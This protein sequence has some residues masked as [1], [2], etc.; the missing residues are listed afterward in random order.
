MY[1][2][3]LTGWFKHWDFALWDLLIL[4]V[5][6]AFAYLLR[7]GFSNPYES[8][9]YR[10][11][12]LIIL[13]IHIII[14]F[15]TEGYSGIVRR[16]F[17]MEA[18]RSLIHS[19]SVFLGVILYEVASKTT[20]YYSRIFVFSYWLISFFGLWIGRTVLKRIV[21]MRMFRA[22]N[23][24]V[25]IIMTLRQYAEEIIRQMRHDRFHEFKV[26][27][28]VL[29]D[30]DLTGEVIEDVPVVSSLSK[31]YEYARLNV[32]D[33]VFISCDNLK[34]EERYA[35][36][37]IEMGITAHLDILG[38][39]G[40]LSDRLVE[41]CG[42]YLVLTSSMNTASPPKLFIKR[43]TD[44]LGALVGL[45]LTGI[46]FVI[47]APII[48]HQSPGPVF[49]KQQRIGQNGRRFTLYKFRSMYPDADARKQQLLK[50]NEMSG[51]MFK[52]KDDPRII[53]IGRFMR[54]FS[55]DE[56][57]QF[58]NVLKGDMSL[59]GTRPPTVEEF[60]HYDMHHKARLGFRPG[61]T[62]L[63]QISGRNE[64]RDFE[65]VVALDTKY[66]T[67]WSLGLDFQI[68]LKTVEVVLKGRG[69]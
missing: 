40:Q 44:I 43:V 1:K 47:F 2:R 14:I 29:L 30:E 21:R 52:M 65:R 6:F 36:E 38:R 60:E 63:W 5:C 27:G 12:A 17:G 10:G 62:G 57:P 34:L 50:E 42:G 20:D 35:S 11:L 46:F 56:F 33:E 59:V 22:K 55:I 68:L 23:R 54:R 39:G 45:F 41:R 58:F 64:I 67:E 32:V 8:I 28:L 53:P 24:P 51:H 16:T 3:S 49:Y 25:M 15:F 48:K 13:V 69:A 31:F 4:Q 37:L 9:V 66:I 7:F 26:E 61:L 18:R 19:T